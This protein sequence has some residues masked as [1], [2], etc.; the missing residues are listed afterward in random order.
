MFF[1]VFTSVRCIVR[2]RRSFCS[3]AVGA[4]TNTQR[5]ENGNSDENAPPM[6]CPPDKSAIDC[7]MVSALTVLND[8]Q[9]C[10]ISKS[11]RFP[12]IYCSIFSF[13]PHRRCCRRHPPFPRSLTIATLMRDDSQVRSLPS[14]LK[15]F[16]NVFQGKD[17]FRFGQEWIS[18]QRVIYQFVEPKQ[19]I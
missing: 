15:G 6:Q 12:P 3:Q 2:A 1:L 10:L 11:H 5:S 7:R 19:L 8:A 18:N 17:I 13:P 14:S 16:R 9:P 4:I